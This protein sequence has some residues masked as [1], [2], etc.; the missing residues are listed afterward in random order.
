MHTYTI[1]PQARGMGNVFVVHVGW[2]TPTAAVR[3]ATLYRRTIID[4][5]ATGRRFAALYDR[6]AQPARKD[7]P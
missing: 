3:M 1:E 7:T 6:L 5:H 2:V 4:A